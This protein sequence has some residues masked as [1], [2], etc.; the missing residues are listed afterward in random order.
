M[1][2]EIKRQ[3][4]CAIMQMD[5]VDYLVFIRLVLLYDY[6]NSGFSS[7]ID[8]MQF[9]IEHHGVGRLANRHSGDDAMLVQVED[10]QHGIR[11]T[12]DEQPAMNL[13]DRHPGRRLATL[14]RPILYNGALCEVDGYYRIGILEIL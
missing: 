10:C 4:V 7:R 2:L 11:V 9:G 5:G 1:R 12:S 8:A 6:Q 13:I 14:Q 3:C